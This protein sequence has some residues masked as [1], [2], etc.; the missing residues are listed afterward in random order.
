M[1]AELKRPGAG[2]S[3]RPQQRHSPAGL[4]E[5]QRITEI[6][7]VQNF[8]NLAHRDDDA[9]VDALAKQGIAFVPFFPLGGFTPLQSSELDQKLAASDQ[10]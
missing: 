5:G 2:S 10:A 6:V 1:L 8:Y 4:Q 9:F 3:Y 7:C